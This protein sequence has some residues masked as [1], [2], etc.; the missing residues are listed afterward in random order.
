MLPF[1]FAFLSYIGWGTGDIFGTIAARK[2]GAYATTFWVFA[3]GIVLFS[4]YI[5]F[6]IDD[7]RAV[8][9]PLLLLNLILGFF[10]ISGNVALNEALVRSNPSMVL[11]ISGSFAA[12]VVILSL[13]FLG[14]HITGIQ[15]LVI[16]IIFLGVFLCTFN[17]GVLKKKQKFDTG[18]L[19]ALYAMISF[20]LY[21]TFIK[22]IV[23]EIGWFWPNFISFLWFP[24]IYVYMKMKH[25]RVVDPV[26]TKSLF[27]IAASAFLLR[28]ADFA[29]NVGISSGLTS[30]VAPIAGAYPTLSAIIAY[31]VF[32]DPISR[33]QILG[34]I[35]TLCGIVLLSLLST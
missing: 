16:A 29:F 24:M 5:P 7:L 14:E 1:L 8:T 22:S 9:L 26:T 17:F 28:S 3:V 11:T 35:I 12:L 19:Y 31:K 2:I 27:P 13:I 32:K 6:A 25:I 10:Y 21:F 15:G 34:I 20:A 23:R 18:I 33:Q 30:I 4:L